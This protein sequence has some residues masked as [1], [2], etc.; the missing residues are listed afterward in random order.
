MRVDI[1]EKMSEGF[2]SDELSPDFLKEM[3]DTYGQADVFNSGIT[4]DGKTD[5]EILDNGFPAQTLTIVKKYRDFQASIGA[6]ME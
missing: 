6:M 4:T 3:K 1:F 2:L 5:K